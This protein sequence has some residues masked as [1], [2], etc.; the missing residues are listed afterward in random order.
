MDGDD[1]DHDDDHDDDKAKYDDIFGH[2]CL[3]VPENR[4]FVYLKIVPG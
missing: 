2:R 1:N 4:Y 3:K